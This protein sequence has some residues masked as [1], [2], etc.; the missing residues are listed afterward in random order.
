MFCVWNL[1]FG[2]VFEIEGVFFCAVMCSVTPC[3]DVSYNNSNNDNN[4]CL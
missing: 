4:T 2:K 1:E 3:S